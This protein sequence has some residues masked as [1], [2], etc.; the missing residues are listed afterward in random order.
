MKYL[1][2]VYGAEKDLDALS[3]AEKDTIDEDSMR[4]DDTLMESGHLIVAHALKSVREAT[5]VQVRDDEAMVMDGPFAETKEQLLGF[6]LI[7]ARDKQEAI[8][9]ASEVPLAKYGT[10]EVRQTYEPQDYRVRS[11]KKI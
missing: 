7:E 4:H 11:R 5:S 9:I 1:C 3:E 8:G 10:V 2:L 6:L